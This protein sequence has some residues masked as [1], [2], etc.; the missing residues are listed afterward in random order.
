MACA[1]VTRPLSSMETWTVT[2]IG[3]V[4]AG[5]PA[6]RLEGITL[7][8]GRAGIGVS[9]SAGC[10]FLV[11]D[12]AVTGGGVLAGVELEREGV[13]LIGRLATSGVP[14]AR[15]VSIVAAGTGLPSCTGFLTS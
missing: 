5:P 2:S 9:E 3:I 11:S 7:T 15:A 4:C 1:A 12:W 6:S 8:S 13:W 14:G 10:M